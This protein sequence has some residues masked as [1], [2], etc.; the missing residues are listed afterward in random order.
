MRVSRHRSGRDDDFFDVVAAAAGWGGG[1]ETH[2]CFGL[3][4]WEMGFWEIG[5]EGN[6]GGKRR[7]RWRGKQDLYTHTSWRHNPIQFFTYIPMSR[8]RFRS[9]TQPRLL[10]I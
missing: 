6:L 9:R 4:I 7:E 5:E 3:E 2:I 10:G 8:S 1:E